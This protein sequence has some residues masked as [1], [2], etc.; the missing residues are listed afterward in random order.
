MTVDPII[1]AGVCNLKKQKEINADFKT[2]PALEKEN[3][4]Q[5]ICVSFLIWF[6]TISKHWG[7]ALLK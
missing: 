7:G 4:N 2:K 5:I 1:L 3:T 6:A